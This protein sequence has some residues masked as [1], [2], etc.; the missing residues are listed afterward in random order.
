MKL[1]LLDNGLLERRE[2]TI[3]VVKNSDVTQSTLPENFKKATIISHDRQLLENRITALETQFKQ[4]SWQEVQRI[5]RA[6]LAKDV[7][8]LGY[9]F[10]TPDSDTGIDI[11]WNSLPITTALLT[12]SISNTTRADRCIVLGSAPLTLRTPTMSAV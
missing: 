6:G 1:V 2:G 11:V 8:P 9:E 12:L 5:V 10:T 7:F 3:N 4:H